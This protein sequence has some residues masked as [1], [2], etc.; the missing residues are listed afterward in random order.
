MKKNKF[1]FLFLLTSFR[2]CVIIIETRA[3]LG[4]NYAQGRENQRNE[5]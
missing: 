2:L 4:G 1:A 5:F 3:K